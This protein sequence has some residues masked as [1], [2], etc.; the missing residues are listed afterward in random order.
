MN[1]KC[2]HCGKELPKTTEFFS[3]YKD[4]NNKQEPGK[5]WHTVCKQC[6]FKSKLEE[7]WKDGLLKCHV[8]GKYFPEETFHRIGHTSKKIPLSKQQR[9]EMSKVQS[10]YKQSM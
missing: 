6:E 3:K 4:R 5:L 10:P 1:Q 7:N 2:S 9:Q 8:C